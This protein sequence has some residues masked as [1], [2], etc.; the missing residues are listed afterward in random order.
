MWASTACA[1][2][3]PPGVRPCSLLGTEALGASLVTGPS[4]GWSDHCVAVRMRLVWLPGDRSEITINSSLI[5]SLISRNAS[6][7]PAVQWLQI[8]LR[9]ARRVYQLPTEHWLPAG[10][11]SAEGS[12]HS[13]PLQEKA[14]WPLFCIMVLM[15]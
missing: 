1:F 4:Q 7:S 10:Q 5:S 2:S 9:G 11:V 14:Q 6:L 3:L 15:T 12:P 13:D 8:H